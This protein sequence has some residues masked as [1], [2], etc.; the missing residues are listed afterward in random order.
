M[1]NHIRELCKGNEIYFSAAGACRAME[2]IRFVIVITIVV[3]GY[4]EI[5]NPSFRDTHVTPGVVDLHEAKL[6]DLVQRYPHFFFF[7]RMILMI[8]IIDVSGHGVVN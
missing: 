3:L 4:D 1:I 7:F 8:V 2:V 6:K 5:S